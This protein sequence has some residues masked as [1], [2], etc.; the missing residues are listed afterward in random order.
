[1]PITQVQIGARR[2][3]LAQW[4][5]YGLENQKSFFFFNSWQG[6]EIIVG[7]KSFRPALEP[8]Q[9]P[10]QW[11]VRAVSPGVKQP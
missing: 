11:I 8:I 9:A 2:A 5:S 4:V 10:F 3:Q 1:M 7:S 6:H